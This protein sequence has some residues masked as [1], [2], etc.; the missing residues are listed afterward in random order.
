MTIYTVKFTPPL[1]AV[2]NITLVNYFDY[3]LGDSLAMNH[4]YRVLVLNYFLL[5]FF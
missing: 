1:Y 5:H 2:K 4:Y 3:F